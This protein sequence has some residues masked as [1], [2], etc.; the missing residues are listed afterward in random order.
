MNGR[1]LSYKK[2]AIHRIFHK[3]IDRFY[4][5][6]FQKWKENSNMLEIVRY[7]NEEG[8]VKMEVFE[9]KKEVRALRNFI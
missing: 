8:P 7:M 6:V 1:K 5:D 2:M 9:I 3:N 4:R